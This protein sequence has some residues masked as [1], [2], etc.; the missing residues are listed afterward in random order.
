MNYLDLVKI[1][2]NNPQAAYKDAPFIVT[3][4]EVLL[5]LFS[6]FIAFYIFK[7]AI[8]MIFNPL[9]KKS[10]NKWDDFLVKRHFFHRLSL[11]V[12]AIVFYLYA[13]LF[14]SIEIMI[15]RIALSWS[16]LIVP[17][18]LSTVLMSLNDGYERL[19]I[20][21]SKPIKGV[22]Q[23]VVILSYLAAI[24]VIVSIVINKS[25]VVIL[26][27]IGAMTAVL[28][29]VF[30]DTL[31]SFVAGLQISSNNTIR[32][33]DWIVMPQYGADGNV[34]D[35]SLH[36]IQIQNW[37]KTITTIPTH[38]LLDESF[39]NWRGMEESGGRRISRNININ[40]NSV[41][42]LT[43]KELQELGR[44]AL[45]KDYIN[46]KMSEIIM[47]ND[48]RNI[49][50]GHEINGRQLTNIGTFR[51]YVYNYLH[52][53]SDIHKEMTLLVRQLQSKEHGIPLQVYAFTTITEWGE[54]ENIQSDIFDHL[55][56]TAPHFHLSL[57]QNPSS[58]DVRMIGKRE[59]S[60]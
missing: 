14:P 33:G 24:I 57:F 20:S 9:I 34:I 52:A 11:V 31:L 16:V 23:I 49:D 21:K 37:D 26:S 10:K 1:W 7:I 38:K 43:Q 17:I 46:E 53:R 41:R 36:S 28:M 56:A 55:I 44:I 47:D 60:V 59:D 45:I 22:L 19:T 27:G 32:K 30:K 25:P 58:E 6:A 12:P 13:P 15:R 35:I 18:A 50:L 8:K 51:A 42:F 48:T 40:T 5:I 54:Y 2:I 39:I 4:A 29:L 3:I